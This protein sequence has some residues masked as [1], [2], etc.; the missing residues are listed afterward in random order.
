M[1]SEDTKI[2]KGQKFSRNKFSQS[3]DPKMELIFTI[4]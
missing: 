2:P 3:T 1:P 4:R